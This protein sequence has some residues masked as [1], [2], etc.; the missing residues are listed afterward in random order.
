MAKLAIQGG[1]PVRTKPF[2]Q[3]P[4]QSEEEINGLV[5][6]LKSNKWGSLKGNKVKDF[7]NQYAAFH[8]AKYGICVNSGTTALYLALRAT[9]IGCGDEV[10]LPGYTFIATATA[11]I[12][13]GATPVF[14]DIDPET[15]N[16]D[17]SLLEKSI[18]DKT[19][20]IMLVHFGGRPVDMDAINAVAKKH[21]LKVIEDAAQAW[22][23]E[24]NGEKVGKL[25]DAGCFSFQSSKNITS[26]EGGIILTNDP[27]TAKYARSF[28]NCGRVEGGVWYE[29]YYLGGNYRMTEFQGAILLAQFGRYPELKA[30]RERNAQILNDQ[31]SSIDGV[32]TLKKD[33]RITSNS[34]HLYIWRYDKSAFNNVPK[35]KFIEAM[36]SEGVFTSN[37]YS[38]PL[39]S[40]PVMKDNAFGPMG[41]K[42]D[43]GIDYSSYFLPET[44]KA[45][46][47]E[48]I[49]FTQNILL[50][51][52]EDMM[53]IVS[54]V[55]KIQE[56]SKELAE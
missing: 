20:A 25:G 18:T 48:A 24:W 53:D 56:N 40:Q 49:W 33:P 11:I 55:K 29:H 2:P 3:W 7:E 35:S 9:G 15:Y 51:E 19:R 31:L 17:T 52:E 39:Y 54:A 47:E 46:F 28:S 4:Y 50:G 12:E 30:R 10:L 22:G 14:V 37:G 41:R 38:V 23:S 5:E 13:A 42:V 21:N 8:D 32:G 43:L 36:K 44:E 27:E 16:I 6:V 34:Y 26:A 45:C 1:D